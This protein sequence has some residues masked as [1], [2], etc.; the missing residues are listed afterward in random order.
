MFKAEKKRKIEEE[1]INPNKKR[2]TTI[3]QTTVKPVSK[4]SQSSFSST[5]NAKKP[6]TADQIK[7][8]INSPTKKKVSSSSVSSPMQK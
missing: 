4:F 8:S 5:T 6:T 7:K 2:G 1:K 3:T